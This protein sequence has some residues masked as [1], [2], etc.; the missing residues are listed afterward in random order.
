MNLINTNLVSVW[1][2][3]RFLKV[4][5]IS[6][7]D[8]T[9]CGTKTKELGAYVAAKFVHLL[10]YKKTSVLTTIYNERVVTLGRRCQFCKDKLPPTGSVLSKFA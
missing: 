9:V 1:T 10:S 6:A 3:G 8:R 2:S 7:V 4:Y 5:C